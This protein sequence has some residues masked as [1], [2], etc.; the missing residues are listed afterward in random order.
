V[1]GRGAWLSRFLPAVVAVCNSQQV[2]GNWRIQIIETIFELTGHLV[3]DNMKRPTSVS[4]TGHDFLR[5]NQRG[6]AV[7]QIITISNTALRWP[8]NGVVGEISP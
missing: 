4:E 2:Q 7:L 5:F 6:D 1:A 8:S 3:I